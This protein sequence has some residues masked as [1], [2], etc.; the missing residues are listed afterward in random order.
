MVLLATFLLVEGRVDDDG[1]GIVE[2]D[3]PPFSYRCSTDAALR[4][5]EGAHVASIVAGQNTWMHIHLNVEELVNGINMLTTPT[6]GG[7]APIN[8]QLM[9]NLVTGMEIE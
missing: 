6:S 8:M 7:Y 2:A 3:D 1:T 4:E 5:L 9:D